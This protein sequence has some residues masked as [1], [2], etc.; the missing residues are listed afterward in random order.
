MPLLIVQLEMLPRL[1]GT[2]NTT[3]LNAFS[4]LLI[5]AYFSVLA[6]FARSIIVSHRVH[7]FHV[8]RLVINYCFA[9]DRAD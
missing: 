5:L 1:S 4:I 6:Y 9:G 8:T 2:I 7:A 3:A